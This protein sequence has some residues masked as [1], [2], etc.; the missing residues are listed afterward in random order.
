MCV[1]VSLC[2]CVIINTTL[3]GYLEEKCMQ[4]TKSD[5]FYT[6]FISKVGTNNL[7]EHNQ[8]SSFLFRFSLLI[9]L[10]RFCQN[11]KK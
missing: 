6:S 9:C 7:T 3:I 11:M 5:D 10:V 4:K 8:I 1:Y 2:V